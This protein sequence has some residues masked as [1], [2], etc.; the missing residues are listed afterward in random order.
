MSA[1]DDWLDGSADAVSA[2]ALA[3]QVREQPDVARALVAAALFESDLSASYQRP[4]SQRLP[5]A[6]VHPRTSRRRAAANRQRQRRPALVALSA[7]A[8]ALLGLG[9][10]WWLSQTGT[11][12]SPAS[13]TQPDSSPTTAVSDHS[14]RTIAWQPGVELELAPHSAIRRGPDGWPLVE[15]GRVTMRVT[16]GLGADIGL[17]DRRVRAR[18]TGTEF[19]L[20]SAERASLIS[21]ADGQVAA[22]APGVAVDLAANGWLWRGSSSVAGIGPA[23]AVTVAPVRN[24]HSVGA[25]NRVSGSADSW[26]I[27]CTT[28]PNSNAPFQLFAGQAVSLP[29]ATEWWWHGHLLMPTNRTQAALRLVDDNNT[30]VGRITIA[31]HTIAVSDGWPEYTTHALVRFEEPLAQHACVIQVANDELTVWSNGVARLTHPL[32][33]AWR[34]ATEL[35][36]VAQG[37]IDDHGPSSVAWQQVLFGQPAPRSD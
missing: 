27:D 18:V 34:T 25:T 7:A 36:M 4:P 15:R 35:Q 14:A 11:S 31:A 8:C 5:R 17:R 28:G 2:E 12:A 1:I 19:T 20:T 37:H 24:P 21:V 13:Q 30:V 23:P 6:Q 22:S 26:R 33:A 3:Q 16:P 9:A 29:N 10:W 32:P